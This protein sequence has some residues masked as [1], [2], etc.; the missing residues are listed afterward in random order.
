MLFLGYFPVSLSSQQVEVF[1][2]WEAPEEEN[3]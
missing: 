3:K 1:L 2:V